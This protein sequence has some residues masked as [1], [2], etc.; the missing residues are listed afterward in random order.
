MYRLILITGFSGGICDY[1]NE[2]IYLYSY[3]VIDSFLLL[4]SII[5]TI[6][7]HFLNFLYQYHVWENKKGNIKMSGK[8]LGNNK[9]F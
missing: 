1:Y 3:I 9:I 6:K 4:N 5:Q 7:I 8:I 2:N